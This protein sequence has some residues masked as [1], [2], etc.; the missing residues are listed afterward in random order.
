MKIK[1]ILECKETLIKLNT[2]S[3]L[4]SVVAYRIGK[5]IKAIDTEM[6]EYDEVRVKLLKDVALKD[7]NGEPIINKETNNYDIPQD[8]LQKIIQ[9]IDNLQNEEILTDKKYACKNQN[10]SGKPGCGSARF[11]WKKNVL[12]TG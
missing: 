6:Q 5:N 11:C 12:D 9:E 1:D 4:P 3:G 10:R 8:Q 2:I 7:E